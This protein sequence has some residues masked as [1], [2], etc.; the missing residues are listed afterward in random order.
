MS[1]PDFPTVSSTPVSSMDEAIF[2]FDT[3]QTGGLFGGI[4][5]SAQVAQSVANQAAAARGQ[6]TGMDEA[7]TGITDTSST[8]TSIGPAGYANPPSTSA[9][10]T[11]IMGLGTDQGAP[12]ATPGTDISSPSIAAPS[13]SGAM[14]AASLGYGTSKGGEFSGTP[15]A[16]DG[17]GGYGNLAGSVGPEAPSTGPSGNFG[18]G[19]GDISG[20]QSAASM[21]FGNDPGGEFGG[22]ND[23]GP[24]GPSGPSGGTGGGG[25]DSGGA[26]NGGGSSGGSSGG[27]A[28]T[29]SDN[30]GDGFGDMGGISGGWN[31]GGLVGKKKK[32]AKRKPNTSRGIAARKK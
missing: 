5:V 6:L 22:G 16:D 17:R 12:N 29:G 26:A 32:P 9:N 21:G 8:N 11:G 24:S 1:V 15:T 4:D 28:G 7:I 13:I 19:R 18:G 23:G 30:D 14:S 27:D 25:A 3:P 20:A 31:K 2:G 10:L